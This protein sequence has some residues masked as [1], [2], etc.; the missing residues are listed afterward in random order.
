MATIDEV[1]DCLQ[2]Y[3]IEVLEFDRDTPTSETAAAAVG[4]SVAQIAKS[5][6]L[7]VGGS[8]LLVVASGDVKVK[9]SLL[10]Q[11]AGLT[12][13]VRFPDPET[14]REQT[15]YAPGGVCPFLLP[16]GVPVFIDASL[17]RFTTV[18]PAAGNDRSAVPITVDLLLQLT[19]GTETT[20]CT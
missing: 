16:K 4:C 11:A 17:R 2:G 14:V 18:Y 13:K 6:L 1:K 8:P 5:M 15:G 3:D 9:S 10:K 20:V 19:G 12:G 7:L